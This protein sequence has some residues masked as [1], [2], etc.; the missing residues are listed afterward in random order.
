MERSNEPIAH[1][2]NLN[3]LVKESSF[4]VPTYQRPYSWN[5]SQIKELWDD[6]VNCKNDNDRPA[7]QDLSRIEFDKEHFIG[8]FIFSQEGHNLKKVIDGQQRLSTLLM[9]LSLIRTKLKKF[10]NGKSKPLRDYIRYTFLSENDPEGRRVSKLKLGYFDKDFFE[11]FIIDNESEDETVEEMK[12]F[13]ASYSKNSR[14]VN[15]IKDG[16]F[17]FNEVIDSECTGLSS[18]EKIRFLRLLFYTIIKGLTF[19]SFTVN[20]EYPTAIFETINSRGLELSEADLIKSYIFSKIAKDSEVCEYFKKWDDI[21]SEVGDN[22]IADYILFHYVSS[23]KYKRGR[24]IKND[25]FRI[26]KREFTTREQLEDYFENLHSEAS[27]YSELI[28][29]DNSDEDIDEAYERIRGLRIRRI[30][31]LVLS[32]CKR[33]KNRDDYLNFLSLVNGFVFRYKLVKE[34]TADELL[35]KVG[36]LAVNI[37]NRHDYSLKEFIS[38]INDDKLEITDDQVKETLSDFR[39]DQYIRKR[40]FFEIE[41]KFRKSDGYSDFTPSDYRKVSVEHILPESLSYIEN[42]PS[43]NDKE[44]QNFHWKLGNLLLVKSTTNRDLGGEKFKDK[45]AILKKA[46]AREETAMVGLFLKLYKD[47][48]NWTPDIIKRRTKSIIKDILN[49][50]KIN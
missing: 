45:I 35:S 29:G 36:E 10:S 19:I 4:E 11:R 8:M 48:V 47:E 26:I 21:V 18:Q 17:F 24:K 34:K 22:E 5:R 37:R 32:G 20:S 3:K 40:I 44:H 30:Y 13:I 41:K 43:F 6:I 16:Y 49:I 28:K 33:F 38:D 7:I 14:S 23:Y 27:T 9:L 46:K 25:L 31:P 1:F 39:P 50:W 15:R 12:K 42:F 2:E